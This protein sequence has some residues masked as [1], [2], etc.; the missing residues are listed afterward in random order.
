MLE[1][2]SHGRYSAALNGYQIL[3][4]RRQMESHSSSNPPTADSDARPAQHRLRWQLGLC[5][6]L[7][8]L[9]LFVSLRDSAEA[10]FRSVAT[11]FERSQLRAC[12][13]QA[14]WRLGEWED[15]HA[16]LQSSPA[17]ITTLTSPML[18][19]ATGGIASFETELSRAMLAL[20]RSEKE[21]LE[22]HCTAARLCLVPLIAAARMESY[23]R[24]HG[25]LTQLQALQELQAAS[26]VLIPDSAGEG[27]AQVDERELRK[28]VSH[29]QQRLQLL[30]DTPQALEPILAVRCAVLD[31][32][33]TKHTGGAAAVARDGLAQSWLALAKGA[34]AAG[35]VETAANALAQVV[36]CDPSAAALKTAKMDWE[37][38]RTQQAILRLQ[39]QLR[40]LPAE[41]EKAARTK[42]LLLLARY[43]EQERG[44]SEIE[45]VTELL[46]E[47]SHL[48]PD[49]ESSQ[50]Y[51]GHFLDRAL[52]DA[53]ARAD[54]VEI[55][56]QGQAP[57]HRSEFGKKKV[58]LQER[59]KKK[60]EAYL[61]NLTQT[62]RCYGAALRKGMRHSALALP[63]MLS[64]WL[65]FADLQLAVNAAPHQNPQVVG[66]GVE[67]GKA[68]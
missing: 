26:L 12:A 2:E 4:V 59:Q 60:V 34:R 57:G 49:W 36:R 17:S 21:A 3:L 58:P 15:V 52:S 11:E 28:L 20:H 23:G 48:Q 39:Q 33:A 29:W 56:Q 1:H 44:L 19:A 64:L 13:L 46:R 53:L 47:A 37:A 55:V 30:P 7:R 66:G 41:S 67:R 18:P 35:H 63:R 32:V 45:I 22:R 31:H 43:L 16:L 6:S 65:D 42:T 38:G 25:H 14:T 68:G 8:C 40:A 24:A 51:L 27:V 62:L 10:M 5:R 61:A 54:R 9:G 50:F